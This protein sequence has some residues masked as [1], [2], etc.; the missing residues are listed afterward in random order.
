MRVNFKNPWGATNSQ[1]YAAY[2]GIVDRLWARGLVII[3]LLSDEFYLGSQTE[4]TENHAG[5]GHN[6]YIDT[7]GYMAANVAQ[8]YQGKIQ[9]WEVWNEPNCYGS[10]PG[11]GC[12][13]IYPSNFAAL[14]AHVWTQMRY[15]N[16]FDVE[17]ISGG[18]LG[19]S[20]GSRFG[21]YSAG[22]SET[23]GQVLGER[24]AP[25]TTY[26]FKS[27]AIGGGNNTGV[28]PYQIG[29]AA[30]GNNLGTFVHLKTSTR[31]V[32]GNSSWT[33]TAGVTYTTGSSGTLIGK[34]I[35]IRL[36]DGSA[37]GSSDIWYDNVT[38]TKQ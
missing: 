32:T 31:S 21:Y 25:N 24:F 23:V 6:P 8:R 22:T 11:N 16:N 14:L 2:D 20:L 19:H 33:E 1:F 18:L 26:T 27:W 17:V 36:G 12:T 3:G 37:G 4:W 15:Y 35:I 34:Q 38:V 7:F 9:Y 30:T 28:V 29:Y 10:S 5:N 13:Y